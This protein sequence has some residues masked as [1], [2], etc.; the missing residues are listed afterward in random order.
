MKLSANQQS[1][2]VFD[3]GVGG[4]SV[5]SKIWKKLPGENYLYIADQAHVPYGSKKK[6]DILEYSFEIS[7]YLMRQG[8]KLIVLACNTASAA[9]LLKLRGEY[10]D[11]PFVGM[12]PAVK[13]AAER[14]ATG[15]VGVLAT[16]STFS[17]DL[18]SSLVTRFGQGAKILQHTC[19]GLVDEIEAGRSDGAKARN[20]L[21]A[22]LKP[23]IEQGLDS[24]VLGCTHYPFAEQTIRSIAGSEVEI[25]DPAPAIA[26]RVH[27]FLDSRGLLRKESSPG[28]VT[29]LTSGDAPALQKFLQ[30]HFTDMSANMSLIKWN[31]GIIEAVN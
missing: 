10:P 5:L 23:M 19:P 22:A 4:L 29:M 8:C 21:E 27:S 25:Y 13:P 24:I 7:R 1:I 6:D 2:G 17:G 30:H 9:A 31:G 12:E 20:I 14:S 26:N 16:P 3:S 15:V 28:S 11:L 18:F